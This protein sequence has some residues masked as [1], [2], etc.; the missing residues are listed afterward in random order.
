MTLSK[1]ERLENSEAALKLM[2]EN[3]GDDPINQRAFVSSDPSFEQAILRT[4]WEDLMRNGF[5]FKMAE[6]I[7]SRIY[8]LTSKGWLACL[9]ATGASNSEEF[10]RRIGRLLAAMKGYVKGRADHKLITP[11]ELAA[12]C[13]EPFG[14]VFNVID[15]GASQSLNS[16]RIG[17]TWYKGERGR[18]IQIP[19]DFNMEPIDVAAAFS[20]QHLETL[21][22]LQEQVREAQAERAQ[23]HCPDCDAPIVQRGDVDYP[24]HHCIVTY[25]HFGCGLVLAD[26]FEESPCPYGPRWP[27]IE[28]FEFVTQ[29]SPG[30]WTCYTVPKTARARTVHIPLAHADTKER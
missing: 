22:K 27:K 23:Y 29:E 7:G 12:Q 14:W 9:E 17:A 8:Q 16:G 15:S 19:V 25:E 6:T 3:L 21:E 28:E 26:G 4:T 5:V 10:M 2:F 20:V 11:W 24:E 13:K 1:R 18:L 30:L